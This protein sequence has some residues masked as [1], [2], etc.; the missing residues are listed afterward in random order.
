MTGAAPADE[1]QRPPIAPPQNP[2]EFAGEDPGGSGVAI[3]YL[4]GSR[5]SHSWHTSMMNLVAYDKSVGLNVITSMPF[6]V[7]CSGPNS[8]VEG[9][10]LAVSHFLDN[11]EDEWLF[12]V[13]SDM[14][15]KP[16]ALQTLLLSADPVMRPIVGGLCFAMK[17]MGSDGCGG[18]KVM[19]VPTLFMWAKNEG[20]GIGFANRFIYPPDALVQVA[21]TGG[22]FLLIHR[23]VLTQMRVKFGD[24]WFDFVSYGDGAQVSEDLSFCWRAAQIEAPVFVNTSVRITHH[25]ELW[26]G[27]PD[28]HQPPREPMQKMMDAVDG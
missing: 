1:T 19:P 13:D 25:K 22:A 11:T 16:D 28:Y 21:G 7:Y 20:Q 26:L 17:H 23:S 2:S 5:V 14:G 3:A 4:H 24:R 18:F 15:F 12:F 10:N 27:E 6:A 8:L 9:R